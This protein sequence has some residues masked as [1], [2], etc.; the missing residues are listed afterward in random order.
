MLL[1]TKLNSDK[2]A[3]LDKLKRMREE[4]KDQEKSSKLRLELHIKESSH[5]ADWVE[6]VTD[7]AQGTSLL[8]ELQSGVRTKL[9]SMTEN[10]E[11]CR[12]DL[13]DATKLDD[14]VTAA[15][16]NE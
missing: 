2:A 16:T 14:N 9:I 4:V 8:Q 1:K 12:Q 10:I 3:L 5:I 6:T 15:K 7:S 13:N 11:K